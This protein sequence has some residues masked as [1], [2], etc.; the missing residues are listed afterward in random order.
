MIKRRLP[1]HTERQIGGG[2]IHSYE[3]GKKSNPEDP[4]N[5]IKKI[6]GSYDINQNYK[7][8]MFNRLGRWQCL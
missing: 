4:T 2:G 5:S 8:H 7:Y 3:I 1:S 6:T